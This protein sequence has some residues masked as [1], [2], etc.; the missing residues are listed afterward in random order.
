M[1]GACFFAAGRGRPEW[2]AAM[3]AMGFLAMTVRKARAEPNGQLKNLLPGVI[4]TNQADVAVWDLPTV[5]ALPVFVTADFLWEDGG[6]YSP[7]FFEVR[8]YLYDPATD[9]Y[10]LGHKYRTA[11]KYPGIDNWD[12]PPEVLEKEWGRIIEVLG[13][14]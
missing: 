4:V 11:H 3:T 14:Q 7:H 8:M 6:H 1:L 13:A 12:S 10:K 9:R 5:S 2:S